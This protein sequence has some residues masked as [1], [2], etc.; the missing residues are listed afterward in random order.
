MEIAR[1]IPGVVGNR[2]KS[3]FRRS[4]TIRRPE[5][6]LRDPLEL[7][8][9]AAEVISDRPSHRGATKAVRA[10]EVGP[11]LVH[12]IPRIPPRQILEPE[13]VHALAANGRD[14]SAQMKAYRAS[15]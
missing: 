13:T 9:L 7:I 15:A 5:S 6:A 8:R 12:Q 2:P 10:L 11:V 14:G 3:R 4:P 1:R